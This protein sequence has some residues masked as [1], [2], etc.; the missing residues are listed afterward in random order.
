MLHDRNPK[1]ISQLSAQ[2]MEQLPFLG[3]QSIFH[4]SCLAGK[5]HGIDILKT[6]LVSAF[7]EMTATDASLDSLDV[8]GVS[9]RHRT[10]LR[11]CV[12]HLSIFKQEHNAQHPERLIEPDVVLAAEAL[13]EGASCLAKITGREGTGDVEEVLGVIF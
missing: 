9:E 3:P 10:L 6:G 1:R 7:A 4:V 2:L 12:R 11:D 8:V 13:R 5:V